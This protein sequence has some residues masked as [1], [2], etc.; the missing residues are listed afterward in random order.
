M[1]TVTKRRRATKPSPDVC[2][3]FAGV[4][5]KGLEHAKKMRGQNR[6]LITYAA[7]DLI[8][9]SP[10]ASQTAFLDRGTAQSA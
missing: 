4:G 9:M 6:V 8:L 3:T 5:W 7:G 10:G 1:A 2:M